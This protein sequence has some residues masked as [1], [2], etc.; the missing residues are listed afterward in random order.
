MGMLQEFKE[1]AMRGNV[2]DMA[3]GIVIGGA[4]GGI[5]NSL[6]KDVVMP[7]IGWA[8]SKADFSKLAIELPV[9]GPDN[10]AVTINYGMFLNAVINFLIVA[11]A[12]FLLVKLVNTMRRKQESSVPPAP[13]AQEKL[14]SEIRDLLKE[15]PAAGAGR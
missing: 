13:T 10:N 5:V 3:V 15:R 14:L 8:S 7:P 4:F 11:M 9:N 2:V 1:F 6:V 12:V